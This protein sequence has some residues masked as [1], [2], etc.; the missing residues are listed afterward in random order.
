MRSGIDTLQDHQQWDELY[1]QLPP[2]LRNP[3]FFSGTYRAYQRVESSPVQCF[4]CYQDEHNYL[5]YPYI[6]RNINSL[7]YD[8][9]GYYNDIIGAYG[10]NGPIGLASSTQFLSEYN[11]ELK[12]YLATQKVVT[13]LARYSP[14][15]E[16]RELHTYTEQIDVLGIDYLDLNVVLDG[17][18]CD[19][20][21]K[22]GEIKSHFAYSLL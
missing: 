3:Y 12:S 2:I 13:E 20:V 17:F 10:Y 1:D 16:N 22:N 6:L 18:I 11:D 7:G 19:E 21:F 14:I 8:L 9:K 15:P 5:F 4:W